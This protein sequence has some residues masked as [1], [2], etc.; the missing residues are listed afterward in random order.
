MKEILYNNGYFFLKSFNLYNIKIMIFRK[1]EIRI[2]FVIYSSRLV[3]LFLR[4]IGKYF[5]RFGSG[6]K[7]V[8]MLRLELEYFF[9]EFRACM[10]VIFR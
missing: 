10:L 4:V 1:I 5:F 7:V 8:K 3:C 9:W 2:F 6:R